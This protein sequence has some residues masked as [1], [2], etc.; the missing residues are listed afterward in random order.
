MKRL[1]LKMPKHW[2]GRDVFK[3]RS[4]TDLNNRQAAIR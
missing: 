4:L 2:F 1:F 3:I